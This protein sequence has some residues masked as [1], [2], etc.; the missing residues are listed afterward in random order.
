MRIINIANDIFQFWIVLM[1]IL[2]LNQ[3]KDDKYF[4]KHIYIGKHIFK[5]IT[6]KIYIL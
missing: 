2:F 3:I 1:I 4:T 5:F 6:Q